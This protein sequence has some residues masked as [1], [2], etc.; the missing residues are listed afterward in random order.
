M[1]GELEEVSYELNDVYGMSRTTPSTYHERSYVDEELRQCLERKTHI[2]VYGGTRQGKTCLRK[3]ILGDNDERSVRFQCA[4]YTTRHQMYEKILKDAGAIVESAAERP[5]LPPGTLHVTFP[6]AGPKAVPV[7]ALPSKP[8]RGGSRRTRTVDPSNANEVIDT[9]NAMSFKRVIALEDFHY[10]AENVQREIAG[11]LKLF[12]ENS[13][14]TVLVIGVWLEADRLTY[15]NGDLNHRLISIN[16]DRWDGT[17][18]R[19][20]IEAGEPLLRIRIDDEASQ[21]LLKNC[22]GNVGLLQE[23]CRSLCKRAGVDRTLPTLTAIGNLDSAKTVVRELAESSAPRYKNVLR[24]L[25]LGLTP[26]SAQMYSWIIQVV[27]EANERDLKR[28]IPLTMMHHR[29]ESAHG[30]VRAG[31]TLV[32]KRIVGNKLAQLGRVQ[33]L[34]GIKPYILDYDPAEERLKVVDAEFSL[35][36]S[37]CDRNELLEELLT[38]DIPEK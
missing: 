9:L 37:S 20:V 35:W 36:I 11:D 15:H 2:V 16:A 29:I 1:D 6:V 26:A 14:I 32:S 22:Q 30:K 12:Y 3:H 28:G 34:R 18:L 25:C 19:K 8:V 13:Q 33:H 17:D 31:K 4:S 23:M 5:Q 24:E 38:P 10:L 21:Y 7:V 27:I